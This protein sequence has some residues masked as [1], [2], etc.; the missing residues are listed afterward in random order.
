LTHFTVLSGNCPA[1]ANKAGFLRW[2]KTKT[3]ASIFKKNGGLFHGADVQSE[4]NRSQGFRPFAANYFDH[5]QLMAKIS[6]SIRLFANG[7]A[8]IEKYCH[9]GIGSLA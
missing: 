3:K 1:L 7:I 9:P 4:G 5:L 2:K 6:Y 8:P